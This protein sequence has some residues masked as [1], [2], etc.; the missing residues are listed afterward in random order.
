MLFWV[1]MSVIQIAEVEVFKAALDLLEVVVRT[2]RIDGYGGN[3][4]CSMG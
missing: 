3:S 1:A 2:V 4:R